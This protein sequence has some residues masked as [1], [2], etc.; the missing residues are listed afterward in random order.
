MTSKQSEGLELLQRVGTRV[1]QTDYPISQRL[2]S[3]SVIVAAMIAVE[4]KDDANTMRYLALRLIRMS[5]KAHKI[6][7]I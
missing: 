1:C 6:I 2:Q 4:D 5:E 3:S 7:G